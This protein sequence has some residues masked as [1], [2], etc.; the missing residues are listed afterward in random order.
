MNYQV[1]MVKEQMKQQTTNYP[2]SVMAWPIQFSILFLAYLA[3][4]E[5]LT[6]DT[7]KRIIHRHHHLLNS[8]HCG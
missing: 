1:T 8:N 3:W 5:P 7:I 2:N 6:Y 4:S